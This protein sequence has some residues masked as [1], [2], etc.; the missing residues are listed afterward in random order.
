MKQEQKD[1]MRRTN[2]FYWVSFDP[3]KRM[4]TFISDMEISQQRIKEKC[5]EYGVMSERIL[6]KHFNLA[7]NYLYSQSRCMSWAITGPARFPV[8]S[9]QKKHNYTEAHLDKLV[10]YEDNIE[11]LLK[12][13]TRRSE[14]EDDKKNKWLE[15]IEKLKKLQ[16]MMKD[17]NKL[18]RQ[19]KQSEAEEK[20]KIKLEKNCFGHIGFEA[21]ELRNNLA[22]IKRLEDQVK[23]I[24]R[25]R[26]IKSDSGFEFDGGSVEFDAE[27]IRY[28]IF[29][30]S[31]PEQELRSKLKTYGFKW[32]PKRGAW[33]RGAK[34]IN[35]K[36]IKSILNVQ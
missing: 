25:A 30:D 22:N 3:V 26:E 32:S 28:N 5:Q 20:Y 35:I 13:I 19:G 15:K 29:F 34:T 1:L 18:I 24:D 23:Q 36:T 16:E 17:V 14:T 6:E 2:A 7:M 31:I 9:Q 33:T 12:R 27:E 21:Y 4:D 11:K 10:Q 8:A